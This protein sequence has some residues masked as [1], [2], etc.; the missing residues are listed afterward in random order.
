[1]SK[2]TYYVC[3]WCHRVVEA[4]CDVWVAHHG[5][6]SPGR[7]RGTRSGLPVDL[8]RDCAPQLLAFGECYTAVDDRLGPP[9]MEELHGD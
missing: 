9:D 4:L 3:D 5:V 1:M 7:T 8:C 2:Q 6:L